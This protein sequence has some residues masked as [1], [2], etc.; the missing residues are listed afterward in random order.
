MKKSKENI[1][2]RK[3]RFWIVFFLLAIIFVLAGITISVYK[4]RNHPSPFENRI[5]QS[6]SLASF[7]FMERNSFFFPSSVVSQNISSESETKII[8]EESSSM[9]K[10]KSPDWWLNSGGIMLSNSQ[11]FSTNFG[12]LPKDSSW[13]KLYF[14]T[15]PKDTDDGYYPQNLFRL[16]T[17]D[18]WENFSQSVY[19]NINK[20]NLSES[21][22]RNESNGVLLFNRYLDGNNLYYIGL[23]VDGEAVIKKKI[24]GKYY[25]LA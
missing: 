15:N 22:N 21:K 25:T 5:I 2:D 18:K 23:R 3:W 14:K 16:V 11:E 9:K 20:L 12:P 10:S 8:L 24:A 17:N 1:P 19:F 4:N 6:L 7:P 13:R